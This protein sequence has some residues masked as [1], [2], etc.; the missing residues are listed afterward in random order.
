MLRI[1]CAPV[2]SVSATMLCLCISGWSQSVEFTVRGELRSGTP[3]FYSEYVVELVDVTRRNNTGRG[4]VR[5]DGGF[6]IRNV[7][8]GDYSL[9]VTTFHGD[10]VYQQ[11]VAVSPMT[12]PLEIRL[13]ES[14]VTSPGAK[15][16]SVRQLLHPPTKKAFQSFVAAQ[17]FSSSGD[18]VRAAE[19]LERAVQES[20]DYAEAH[21]NL[22]AQYVRIGRYDDAVTE[23]NRA[24]EIAGPAPVVLCNLASAQARLGKRAEAIESAR[25]ALR[26]DNGSLQAHLVLGSLLAGDPA[27]REEGIHHLELAATQYASARE[28]LKRVRGE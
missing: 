27:S 9:V 24:I 13:P 26:L 3:N 20:P 1:T 6:E 2:L 14:K 16:I 22:G 21:L 18:Y 12:A 19:A 4:D 7:Q 23:L 15:A 11:S 28:I 8:P 17:R 5:A 10:V 25:A